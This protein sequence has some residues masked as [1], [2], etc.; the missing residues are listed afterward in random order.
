M[1]ALAKS[2]IRFSWALSMLGARQ[3]ARLFL[4]P[5]DRPAPAL[6][7]VAGAA[8]SQLGAEMRSFYRAGDEIQTGMV[9]TIADLVSGSSAAPADPMGASLRQ[10]WAAIDR[11]W[12]GSGGER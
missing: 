9:D 1:R 8:E 12:P 3:T 6:D 11:S 4:E 7:A 2:M 10:T 5:W